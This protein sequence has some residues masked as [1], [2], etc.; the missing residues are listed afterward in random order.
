ME[1]WKMGV[2]LRLDVESGRVYR[3]TGT[4]KDFEP[5]SSLSFEGLICTRENALKAVN[6]FFDK[7]EVM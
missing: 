5:I 3:N 4:P 2:R 6:A 1:S 7:Y